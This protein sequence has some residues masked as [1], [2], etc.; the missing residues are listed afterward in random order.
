MINIPIFLS[1]DDNYAPFVATTIAS[2]C[3]N[4]KSFC[5][6]YILDGGISD[7]N[8][9]K[10]CELKS[11]F[12]NFSI[13]FIRIDINS[14]F[15]EFAESSYIT[16]SMYSRFLIPNIKPEIDRAIYS[17]VDVI[18]LGDIAKMYSENLDGYDVGAVWE[19][20]IANKINKSI[21]INGQEPFFSGNLLIDC[22]KW[23]EKN[24]SNELIKIARNNKENRNVY[25][26]EILNL[27]FGNNYKKLS[28]RYCYAVQFSLVNY[29]DVVPVIRHFNGSIKPWNIHPDNKTSLMK[30][31]DDFWFYMK[32]TSFYDEIL[33]KVAN[34]DEQKK[35]TRQLQMSNFMIAKRMKN[36]CQNSR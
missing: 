35:I 21:Y 26:Q 29:D 15:K 34:V 19:G 3:D 7:E 30:N 17:D 36:L 27:Y 20:W 8:K 33:N 23:R 32:K 18:V 4:T 25:D 13:E 22:C 16:K 28:C 31:L 9:R 12:S 1:S 6:F 24:I 5:D 2:I 14:S 11:L 10:I